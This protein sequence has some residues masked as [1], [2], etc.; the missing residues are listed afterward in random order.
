M[1]KQYEYSGSINNNHI[2]L[3]K[4]SNILSQSVNAK[5]VRT[6]YFKLAT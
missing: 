6:Q 5:G 2:R 4:Q 1:K 3:T